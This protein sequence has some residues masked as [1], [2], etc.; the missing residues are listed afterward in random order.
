M[1]YRLEQ[2]QSDLIKSSNNEKVAVLKGFFK[3]GKGEYGEGDEFIGVTVPENRKIAKKA[4]TLDFSDYAFML[5]SSVHEFRL[6]A[7]I[8]LVE[9]YK[10]ADTLCKCAI[11][12]FYLSQLSQINNWDLVDL[13]APYIVGE[14]ANITGD[15]SVIRSLSERKE[16][17]E[18]R[19]AVVSNLSLIRKGKIDLALEIVEKLLFSEESLMHKAN[20]WILREVGK[21]DNDALIVFLDKYCG[22]MPRT[23]LRYSLER[24]SADKR[25]YY[26]S[27]K[28]KLSNNR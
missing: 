12:E 4:I 8:A 16:M 22:T 6:S 13:S 3:T 24:Q 28:S 10:K 17:W 23:T 2:W 25:A 18:R 5:Q 19:I 7:L 20:G 26:M 11:H 15:Y 21:K 9:R 1:L 14:H 27:Q